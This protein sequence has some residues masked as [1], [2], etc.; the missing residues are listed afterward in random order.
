MA[1]TNAPF[2]LRPVRQANGSPWNGES[3]LYYRPSSD[4]NPLYIGDPVILAGTGDAQGLPG[5]VRATGGSSARIT[6][7]VTGFLPSPALLSTGAYLPGSTAGYVYVADGVGLVYQVQTAGTIAVSQIGLNANLASGSGNVLQG[8]GF[9]LNAAT[10]ASA[11]TGQVRILGYAQS[12]VN[13][14]AQYG[15]L[16]VRI[17]LPTEAGLAS[18]VGV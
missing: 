8:S 11:A 1:N 9:T 17:N 6:G 12:P 10:A 14:V 2:G 16:E 15:V 5:V 7:S 13:E 3:T 18:G 4:S